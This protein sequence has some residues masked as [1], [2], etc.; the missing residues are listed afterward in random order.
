MHTHPMCLLSQILRFP[1]LLLT[2]SL[3]VSHSQTLQSSNVTRRPLYVQLNGSAYNRGLQHGNALKLEIAEAILRWKADIQYSQKRDADSLIAEFLHTTDYIP[4]ITRWTPELLEEVKGIA[5]GSGQTFQTIFAYQLLDEIWGYFDKLDANHCS[6]IGAPRTQSHPAYVAQTMD[7]E[8][9]RD[10]SQTVLHIE[11]T[12]AVPEQ[13][14][15]TAAG[16]IVLNGVN[17]ASIGVCCNTLMQLNASRNGLPV[18]FVTRGL[19]AQKSHESVLAFLKKVKHASGQNYILGLGD[20]VYDFEVSAGKIVPFLPVAGKNIVYHTNHPLV[21]DDFKPWHLKRLQAKTPEELK[22]D[23]S[24]VR[25][26]SLESRLGKRSSGVEEWTIKE[27]LRSKDSELYPVCRS[28]TSE[29]TDYTFGSTMMT[30]SDH[31]SL[32]ATSGPPDLSDYVLYSFRS[33]FAPTD[34]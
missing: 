32:Q 23:N 16:L 17:N 2:I 30:L 6:A 33:A 7:L 5:A 4:T 31:P 19:L 26:A 24:R 18:A 9:F 20:S 29:Q 27:T 14:L 34:R 10:G 22:N 21:N 11:E 3:N 13:Y 28:L 15:F 25:F 12:T 1:L 8:K